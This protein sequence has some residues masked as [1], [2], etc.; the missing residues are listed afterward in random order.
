MESFAS[1]AGF[2]MLTPIFSAPSLAHPARDVSTRAQGFLKFALHPDLG[3]Y[4]SVGDRR[5]AG[6]ERE[7]GPLHGGGSAWLP[8][9]TGSLEH[10]KPPRERPRGTGL[11]RSRKV[12]TR[13]R[14]IV[15]L[16]FPGRATCATCS[17]P[18]ARLDV[19]S[20]K[21]DHADDTISTLRT[22]G[23]RSILSRLR[24]ATFCLGGHVPTR[25]LV[26]RPRCSRPARSRSS[27]VVRRDTSVGDPS[28][29]TWRWRMGR[30][31]LVFRE[32]LARHT[33]EGLDAQELH[34]RYPN[35]PWSCQEPLWNVTWPD[36]IRFRVISV[37]QQQGAKEV[38][39]VK[40]LKGCRG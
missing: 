28:G 13:P 12:T 34:P 27:G 36:G 2:P 31:A 10:G 1:I 38:V 6:R 11:S 15:P 21:H 35:E 8:V 14:S 37:S 39:A 20:E 3:C 26:V 9:Q 19:R 22:P 40:D 23:R 7:R 18:S 25:V 24:T 17:Q 30:G 33:W 5:R 4:S 32:G 16:F 29:A